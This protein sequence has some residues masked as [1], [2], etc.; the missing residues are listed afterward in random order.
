L[1]FYAERGDHEAMQNLL[2]NKEIMKKKN[3]FLQPLYR[4]IKATIKRMTHT[5]EYILMREFIRNR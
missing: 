3:S 4:D 2:D 5:E 1:A